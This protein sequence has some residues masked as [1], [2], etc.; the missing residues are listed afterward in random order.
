MAIDS[1]DIRQFV[2]DQ[3]GYSWDVD[4]DG[5]NESTIS[6]TDNENDTLYIPMYLPTEART[7][8]L[9]ELPLIEV[10]LV[11]SPSKIAGMQHVLYD[12]C[13]FDFNLTYTN[14]DNIDI[15]GFGK[16]VA[17]ELCQLIH[18]NF[19]S[20]TTAYYLE[21]LNSGREYYEG[22]GKTMI[23]HRVVECYGNR[24]KIS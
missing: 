10:N 3:I 14:T 2:I 19:I 8:S 17:D 15:G 1:F 9:P 6:V 24:Y 21:V 22:T 18:D 7:G 13:Y 20:V 12:E 4:D 23:F 16:K 5:T 11:T